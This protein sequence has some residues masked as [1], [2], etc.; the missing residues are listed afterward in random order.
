MNPPFSAVANVESRSTEATAR[1]LRPA[2]ARLA[3]G[4]RLAAITGA[5]FAAEAPAWV[6]DVQPPESRQRIWS[7]PGLCPA[8]LCQARHHFRDADFGVRQMPWWRAAARQTRS[9]DLPGCGASA[10]PI[11]A[12][13]PPRLELMHDAATGQGRSSPFPGNSCP[14][15][16]DHH[17]QI[18]R[19]RTGPAPSAQ[20]RGSMPKTPPY[21]PREPNEDSSAAR[22]SDVR[23]AKPFRLQAFDIPGAAPHPTKL[24]QSAAMARSRPPKPSYCPKLPAAVLRDGLL[25]DAQLGN[26]HLRG[27]GPRRLSRGIV[28]RR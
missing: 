13:V 22:L 27:R 2:L 1:H 12:E 23:L 20:A 18:P 15:G 26:R 16:K 19:S 28:D 10:G 7:S 4:G 9:A 25:S 24:V 21:I 8:G 5:S 17:Q 14:C 3:Q 11:N 6:E